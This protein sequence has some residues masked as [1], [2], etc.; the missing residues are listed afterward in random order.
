[1]LQNNIAPRRWGGLFIVVGWVNDSPSEA[2]KLYC[3]V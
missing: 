2:K 1:M 3:V